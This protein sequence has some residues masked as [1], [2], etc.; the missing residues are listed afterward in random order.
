MA[1]RNGEDFLRLLCSALCCSDFAI[2]RTS[3]LYGMHPEKQN[4][5]TWVLKALSDNNTIKVVGDHYNSPTLA[6]NLAEIVLEV[7]DR[8]LKGLY[9]AAGIRRISRFE[10]ALNIAKA[11][12]L[13]LDLIRR[14]EMS[15]LKAWKAKRPR[16]S[17]LRV[18]KIK[19]E[20]ETDLLGTTEGLN[21]MKRNWSQTT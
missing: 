4:F 2:L 18:D 6:D 21:A 5:A 12:G 17:S 7:I 19:K 15:Q 3:V 9:H 8:E 16:D 11:F 13:D 20:I 1:E 10:F 14:T